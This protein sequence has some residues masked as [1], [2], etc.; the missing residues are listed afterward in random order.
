MNSTEAALECDVHHFRIAPREE[1]DGTVKTDLGLFLAKGNTDLF[2]KETAEVPRSAMHTRL[3][4]R[5]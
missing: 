1:L 4:N 2:A 5:R 3:Q